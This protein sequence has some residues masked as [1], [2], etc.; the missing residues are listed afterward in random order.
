MGNCWFGHRE[1]H[2]IYRPFA[3]H[4]TERMIVD[5]IPLNGPRARRSMSKKTDNISTLPPEPIFSGMRNRIL[6][7]LACFMPGAFTLRVRLHRWRGVKIG[8]GVRIAN[9]VLIE[10]AY[11]Q[12]VSIGN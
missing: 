7:A 5:G 12:W 6:G 1:G 3:T 4:K 8:T 10:T 9:D 2:S 11:P